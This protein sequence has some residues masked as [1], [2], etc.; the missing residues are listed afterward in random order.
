MNLSWWVFEYFASSPYNQI[1]IAEPFPGCLP[2]QSE[3]W[4]QCCQ[5]FL[6]AEKVFMVILDCAFAGPLGEIPNLCHQRSGLE[7]RWW[8]TFWPIEKLTIQIWHTRIWIAFVGILILSVSHKYAN[9]SRGSYIGSFP[10]W[11]CSESGAVCNGHSTHDTPT[12]RLKNLKRSLWQL[13]P[14]LILATLLV[15]GCTCFS[16]TSYRVSTNYPHVNLW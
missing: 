13:A 4:H 16:P 15:I 10:V 11:T 3:T 2:A 9:S 14:S 8:S 1:G 5:Y 6:G 12:G 7:L